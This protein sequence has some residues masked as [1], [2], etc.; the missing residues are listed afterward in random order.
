MGA[1]HSHDQQNLKQG[2]K[3]SANLAFFLFKIAKV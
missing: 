3:H 1:L 2:K